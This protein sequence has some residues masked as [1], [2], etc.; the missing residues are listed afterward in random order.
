MQRVGPIFQIMFT[1]QPEIRNYREYCASVDRGA[2]QRFVWKLF[3]QGVYMTPAA[4]LHS[5][6]TLAHTKADVA[7]TLDAVQ[8][9]LSG[10]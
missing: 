6:A 9:A 1:Q 10:I 2:Y 5:I 8:E 4:T 7:F 3:E